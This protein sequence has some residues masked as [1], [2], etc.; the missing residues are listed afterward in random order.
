MRL[1]LSFRVPLAGGGRLRQALTSLGGGGS[2]MVLRFVFTLGGGE[3]RAALPPRP[4]QPPPRAWG[5]GAPP[6]SLGGDLAAQKSCFPAP[7]GLQTPLSG[8]SCHLFPSPRPCRFSGTP[9]LSSHCLTRTV[10][11]DATSPAALAPWFR[12]AATSRRVSTVGATV[13]ANRQ[14]GSRHGLH[15]PW[16]RLS[17][18]PGP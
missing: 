3:P 15:L 6:Q 1:G 17:G 12:K 10:S 9:S 13:Q 14:A 11:A 7:C 8:P 16:V 18:A 2:A 4:E 5:L